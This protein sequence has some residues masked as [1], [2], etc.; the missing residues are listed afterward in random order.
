MSRRE[1]ESGRKR[2]AE[3]REEQFAEAKCDGANTSQSM[4]RRIWERLKH[5]WLA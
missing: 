4:L 5:W 1:V 2:D 3:L